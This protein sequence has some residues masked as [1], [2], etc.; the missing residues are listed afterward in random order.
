MKRYLTETEQRQLLQT[1]K[2]T[3]DLLAQRD[4]HVF[5]ALILTGM[6]IREFSLLTAPQVRQA[7]TCGWLVSLKENCKGK[8]HTNEYLVTHPLRQHLQALLEISDE[9]A[10]AIEHSEEQLQPLVWGRDVAG[11]AGHLSVRSYEARLKEWAVSA[12]LDPRISPHWLRHTR[13]MN[14]INRTRG[15][16][17]LRVA[18]LA[19]NHQSIRST[20][21]YTAMSREQFEREIRMVD[22]GRVPRRVAR[23]AAQ[24][25]VL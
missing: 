6:R 19:L 15:K 22:G 7:L 4:W 10:R 18:K 14:V 21:I 3:A 24:E 23:R 12:G 16:D 5:S 2:R 13:G 25:A 20:G 8:R 17:G 11:K 9:L 1:M